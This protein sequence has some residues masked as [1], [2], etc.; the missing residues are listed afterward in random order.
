MS[1]FHE[2]LTFLY[3]AVPDFRSGMNTSLETGNTFS[4][5]MIEDNQPEG[6]QATANFFFFLWEKIR[7]KNLGGRVES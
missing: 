1:A 3:T 4:V 6:F 5:L 2:L 7:G